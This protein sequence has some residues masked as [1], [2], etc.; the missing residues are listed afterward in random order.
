MKGLH[1]IYNMLHLKKNKYIGI[2]FLRL[3]TGILHLYIKSLGNG[4]FL[5]TVGCQ[6]SSILFFTPDDLGW[7]PD[8]IGIFPPLQME[9]HSYLVRQK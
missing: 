9:I 2:Y 4:H 3:K 7:N 1:V 8:G 6:E 5:A